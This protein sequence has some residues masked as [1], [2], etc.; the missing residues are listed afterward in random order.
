MTIKTY[1]IF[2]CCILGWAIVQSSSAW[3]QST[4]RTETVFLYDGHKS[5]RLG[6]NKIEIFEDKSGELTIYDILSPTISTQFRTARNNNPNYGFTNSAYWVRFTV[7]NQTTSQEDFILEI[8]YPLLDSI[9]LFIPSKTDWI[10]KEGGDA[11]PFN[12]REIR[13]RQVLFQVQQ[14]L[15]DKRVYYMRFVSERSIMQFPMTLWDPIAFEESNHQAQFLFGII[16]GIILFIIINNLFLFFSINSASYG[17]YVLAMIM[18][19][20][21]IAMLTGHAYEYIWWFS[22]FIQNNILPYLLLFL[23][24]TLVLFCRQFLDTYDVFPKTDVW[25]KRYLWGLPLVVVLN[26]VLP[27]KFGFMIAMFI[28]SLTAILLMTIGVLSILKGNTSARYF[29]IAFSTYI[30]GFLIIL[31]KTVG[32]LPVIFLTEYSAQIGAASQV[33]ILS[34]ALG[35]RFKDLRREK[36]RAQRD[37][38][39]VQKE[40]NEQLERSVKTRT[41]ELEEQAKELEVSYRTVSVMSVIGQE[42]TAS[43][44]YEDIF[45]VLHRY[46]SELMDAAFFGI[47]LYDAKKEQITY[48]YNIEK[49][50][51]LPTAAVSL[52]DENS[53]AAWVV[54]NKESVLLNDI[55]EEVHKYVKE[56]IVLTGEV[57]MSGIFMPL[58]VAEKIIGVMTVQ[59]FSKEAYTTQHFNI[60]KTLAAYTAIAIDNAT[61]YDELKVSNLRTLQSIKYAQRIQEAILTD[62]SYI[63]SY[64]DDTFILYKPRDIVSGDF[65]F[66][67]QHEHIRLI[68]CIDCTGHGVPGAFMTMM[69]NDI[70]NQI[71]IERKEWQPDKILTLLDE[72]VKTTLHTGEAESGNRN[73]GMDVSIC[74]IDTKEK[75]L[76]F[77]GAKSPL[78]FVPQHKPLKRI[79]G[80]KYPIGG[81]HYKEEKVYTLHKIDYN[82]GD[83]FYLY[84]DGY[85]DQFNPTKR[86]KYMSRRFRSFLQKISA[87]PMKEQH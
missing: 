51:R 7:E 60:M 8:N 13:N 69:G 25:L 85:Q 32:V 37:A 26:L 57:T 53:I 76:Q 33:T 36:S 34:L 67:F 20:L 3:A 23:S 59:S 71:I 14:P 77:A 19:L 39:R 78:C 11:F 35:A 43:L 31:L 62:V 56:E 24:Y 15:W 84:T 54:R 18:S 9:K 41:A 6:E 66:F 87:M 48:A 55:K 72:K 64:F 81:S 68:V 21:V 17:Y 30:F 12:K 61:A 79:R 4:K 42:V 63:A 70:L 28:A 52:Y 40:L 83:V 47:D 44:N 49:G 74:L 75:Q 73:D 86:T 22:P 1:I 65:Y 50:R 58:I 38:L 27:Y 16:Y 29:V 46:V 5:V 82:P 80:S 2:C 45:Q 10:V